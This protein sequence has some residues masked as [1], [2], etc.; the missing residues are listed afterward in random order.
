MG[1][2]AGVD[3]EGV[4]EGA[5]EGWDGGGGEDCCCCH[6]GGL[7]GDKLD[8]CGIGVGRAERVD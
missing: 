1:E 3:G 8:L 4:W 7:V 2:G 6:F 5:V